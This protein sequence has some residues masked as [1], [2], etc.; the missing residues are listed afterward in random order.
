[1]DVKQNCEYSTIY[2]YSLSKEKVALDISHP[3]N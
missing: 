3:E 1:M 2:L